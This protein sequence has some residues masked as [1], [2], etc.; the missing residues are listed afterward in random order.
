MEDKG[1]KIYNCRHGQ[2]GEREGQH[3]IFIFFVRRKDGEARVLPVDFSHFAGSICLLLPA[4][5]A[6]E[7]LGERLHKGHCG[8]QWDQDS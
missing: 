4:S 3:Y 6:L 5:L 8:Q 7:L 1:I 2:W